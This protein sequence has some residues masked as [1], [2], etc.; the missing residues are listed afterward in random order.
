MHRP[1]TLIVAG[2]ASVLLTVG[3]LVASADA[4]GGN[5]PGRS[6]FA[7]VPQSSS[8]VMSV[9]AAESAKDKEPALPVVKPLQIPAET[10]FEQYVTDP[11][12]RAL[13]AAR[14]EAHKTLTRND[15]L[16]I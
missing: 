5:K 6:G 14:F 7:V 11:A 9:P 15:M 16:A 2:L 13:A 12:V 10:L 8:V 1:L 3:A 4:A